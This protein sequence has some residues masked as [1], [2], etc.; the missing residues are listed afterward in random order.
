MLE[1]VLHNTGPQD[2]VSTSRTQ[3]GKSTDWEKLREKR[4]TVFSNGSMRVGP[5]RKRYPL[6]TLNSGVIVREARR[7]VAAVVVDKLG[8]SPQNRLKT[9]SRLLESS[10]FKLHPERP[11]DHAVE[12]RLQ[13]SPGS[14]RLGLRI[15]PYS[16]QRAGMRSARVYDCPVPRGRR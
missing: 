16:R 6:P 10:T 14:M 3:P 4:G 5:K 15:L 7:T 11:A 9:S 2:A 12:G 13:T 8:K 1:V